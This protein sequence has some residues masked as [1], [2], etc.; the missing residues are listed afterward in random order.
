MWGEF[1]VLQ[2]FGKQK[3]PA[4]NV[5]SYGENILT[6]ILNDEVHG[7][8]P[9]VH[10]KRKKCLLWLKDEMDPDLERSS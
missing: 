6:L 5:D 7:E 1:E 10:E 9:D 4:W 3:K 2:E 8:S